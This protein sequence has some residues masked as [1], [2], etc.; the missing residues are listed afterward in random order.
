MNKEKLQKLKNMKTLLLCGGEGTR[1]HPLTKKIPKPLVKIKNKTIIDHIIEHLHKSGLKD[2]LICSGYKS[3]M[4]SHHF[5]KYNSINA[6]IINSSNDKTLSM[7][8]LSVDQAI[9]EAILFIEKNSIGKATVNYK[10][11][12]PPQ[13]SPLKNRW[14]IV[15]APVSTVN[16]RANAPP[17]ISPVEHRWNFVPARQFPPLIIGQMQPLKFQPSII[18]GISSPRQFPPLI[19]WRMHRLKFHP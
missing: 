6:K 11:N 2:F 13:I 9:K 15:P 10:L 3:N 18:G 16:H 1:L 7:D 19:I 8:G 4:I 12:A 14:N 5:R 17:H